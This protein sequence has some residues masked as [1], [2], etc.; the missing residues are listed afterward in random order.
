MQTFIASRA[1]RVWTMLWGGVP[2][3][4]M[5][6]IVGIKPEAKFV[7]A[8]GYDSGWTTNVPIEYFLNEDS[9]FAWSHDGAPIP[10]EHG[11]PVRL[12]IPQLY[13]W[14]SAKWVKGVRFLE[15]D[16]AGLLGRGRLSHAR[17]ALGAGRWRTIPVV[18]RIHSNISQVRKVGSPPPVSTNCSECKL[19]LPQFP[20][21]PQP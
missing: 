14:K 1:G 9:L 5:A 3:R 12:I 18:L 16:Q 17:R 15:Q 19:Q 13:A 20:K 6:K 10:P 2:T 11:G 21:T 8:F 7:L 4:E